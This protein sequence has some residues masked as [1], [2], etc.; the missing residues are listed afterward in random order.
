MESYY[1]SLQFHSLDFFAYEHGRPNTAT[2]GLATLGGVCQDRYACVIAEFGTVNALGKPYPSAGFTSVYI[3]AHEIGHKYVRQFGTFSLHEFYSIY[4]LGMH[5]D[6]VGNECTSEGFVMSPSRGTEGETLWS[7]CSADI[8][9]TL[10]DWAKCLHD[11]P[12][13]VS[14]AYNS[15]KYEGYPG[16]RITAKHQCQLLLV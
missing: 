2:M 13:N 14:V 8:I 4:S 3:M 9:R 6:A 10:G 12:T 1:S 16:Q 15:W 7:T 5:H 11:K